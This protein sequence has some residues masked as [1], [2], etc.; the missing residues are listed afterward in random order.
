MPAPYL[1]PKAHAATG[2]FGA[3]ALA[4]ELGD[5]AAAVLLGL[6]GAALPL[7]G[8]AA[9]LALEQALYLLWRYT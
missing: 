3:A 2:H 5:T 4:C 8:L 1:L 6:R 9:D 7:R